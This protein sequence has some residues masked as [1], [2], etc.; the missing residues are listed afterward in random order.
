MTKYIKVTGVGGTTDTVIPCN[1]LSKIAV[2]TVAPLEE[3][4][5]IYSDTDIDAFAVTVQTSTTTSEKL[6]EQ[7]NFIADKI[8]EA[9]QLPYDKSMLEVRADEFPSPLTAILIS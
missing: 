8:V 4:G 5:V 9:L 7:A 6:V 2:D 1:N 3:V